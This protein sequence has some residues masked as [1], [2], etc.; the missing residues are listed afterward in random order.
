MNTPGLV[1]ISMGLGSAAGYSSRGV[2]EGECPG[3]IL[4]AT[5]HCLLLALVAQQNGGAGSRATCETKCSFGVLDETSQP[6][7]VTAADDSAGLA[8]CCG[9]CPLL[10]A[11]ARRHGR[12]YAWL[13]HVS[14]TLR[15]GFWQVTRALCRL[16]GCAAPC[17]E[18]Q[19]THTG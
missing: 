9:A 6:W 3:A 10:G 7:S 2:S 17:V 14:C 15:P 11:G 18:Q 5:M 4:S 16:S 1:A 8:G 13:A 19:C 12:R